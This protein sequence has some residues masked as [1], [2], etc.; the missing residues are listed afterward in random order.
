MSTPASGQD[1]QRAKSLS[2]QADCMLLIHSHMLALISGPHQQ[3]SQLSSCGRAFV[4][5]QADGKIGQG[6]RLYRPGS[7]KSQAPV[8]IG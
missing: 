1:L 6:Q 3:S 7:A 4:T 2:Y 8:P 5:L